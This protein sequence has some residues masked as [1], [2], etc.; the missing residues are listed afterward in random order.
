[1]SS[2]GN[3]SLSFSNPV[4]KSWIVLGG[5]ASCNYSYQNVPDMLSRIEVWRSGWPKHPVSSLIKKSITNLLIITRCSTWLPGVQH[6][7]ES[8]GIYGVKTASRYLTPVIVPTWKTWREIWRDGRHHIAWRLCNMMPSKTIR[9]PLH[10]GRFH[11]H[12]RAGN[13]FL[14]TSYENTS[15]SND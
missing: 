10:N 13:A 7:I 5:V 1:M 3:P 2:C 14:L 6:K 9:P 12:S 11:W 4:Y 8:W 15:R